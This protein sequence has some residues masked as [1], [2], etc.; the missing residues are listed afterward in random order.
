MLPIRLGRVEICPQG[1]GVG[2]FGQLRI[3]IYVCGYDF[4][5]DLFDGR[6]RGIY[7]QKVSR[8]TC[9]EEN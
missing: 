3:S 9:L 6:C 1:H 8:I 4:Q 2:Q 7:S 5:S